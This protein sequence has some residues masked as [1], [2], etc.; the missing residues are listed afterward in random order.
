MLREHHRPD[1]AR[2]FFQV[3]AGRGIVDWYADVHLPEAAVASR[4]YRAD[5]SVEANPAYRGEAW[6]LA[7]CTIDSIDIS[8]NAIS[9]SV[10]ARGATRLVINQNHHPGWWQTQD[11]DG[12]IALDVPAGPSE[13]RLRYCPAGLLAGLAV[14]LASLV[15]LPLIW[16]R[17]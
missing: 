7:E 11:E 13:L 8:P 14:S 9:V 6:C 10:R 2:E 15:L 5:G 17:R 12:L 4:F 16:R 3:P 1:V